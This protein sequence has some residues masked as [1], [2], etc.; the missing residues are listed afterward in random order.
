ML[1]SY[2]AAAG[3][4]YRDVV[5]FADGTPKPVQEFM[6]HFTELGIVVLAVVWALV[7]W[8]ARRAPDRTMAAALIGAIGV[9]VSYGISESTKTFLDAERP[10]RT[11][12]DLRIIAHRCPPTGDWSFPSNHATLAGA[13]VAAI[14]AVSWRLGLLALP[15]G[16]LVGFSRVFVGVHYPH[17]VAAGFLIGVVVTAAM[18]AFLVRPTTGLIVSMRE[19]PLLSRLLSAAPRQVVTR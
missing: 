1:D 16:L 6:A 2:L 10:C 19:Q 8:R 9:V 3:D 5:Q 7:F 12:P 15:I 17:D 4:W 18:V 11:F 13:F 14:F